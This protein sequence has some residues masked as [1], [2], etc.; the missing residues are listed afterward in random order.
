[1]LFIALMC[2]ILTIHGEFWAEI[3]QTVLILITLFS[4]ISF[5]WKDAYSIVKKKQLNIATAEEPE[6]V[7][8]LNLD[9]AAKQLRLERASHMLQLFK[10][11]D[12]LRDPK[13]SLNEL[14]EIMKLDKSTCQNII[15][16]L[17]YAGFNEM[18]GSMRCDRFKQLA[19]S[20]LKKGQNPDIRDIMCDIGFVSYE[21]FSNNFILLNKTSPEQ[22]I[23]WLKSNF[24]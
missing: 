4:S 18:V 14:A 19:N 17:G 16:L 15:L 8:K 9:I 5:F 3:Y 10:T 22:Y 21:N 12:L 13:F 6:D 11:N 20:Q 2:F 23:D 7:Q 1:M 24:K